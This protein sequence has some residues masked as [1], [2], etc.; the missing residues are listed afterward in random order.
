M[1]TRYGLEQPSMPVSGGPLDGRFRQVLAGVRADADG[2]GDFDWLALTPSVGP[3]LQGSV[4]AA[5]PRTPPSCQVTGDPRFA[6]ARIS[7]CRSRSTRL[8]IGYLGP[9]LPTN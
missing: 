9:H 6:A 1:S 3:L 4:S 7:P 2:A 5:P 8:V